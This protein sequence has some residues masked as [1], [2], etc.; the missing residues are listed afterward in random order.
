MFLAVEALAFGLEVWSL[1][2]SQDV[3]FQSSQSDPE[4]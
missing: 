2:T 1:D 3:S 4:T